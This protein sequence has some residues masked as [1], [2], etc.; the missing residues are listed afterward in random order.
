MCAM[1]STLS[2]TAFQESAV[3]ALQS[4]MQDHGSCLDMD[5]CSL[6]TSQDTS[7][8]AGPDGLVRIV[9]ASSC[10]PLCDIEILIS[11][12]PESAWAS[13]VHRPALC[14]D[15]AFWRTVDKNAEIISAIESFA[16]SWLVGD[17]RLRIVHDGKRVLFSRIW[18]TKNNACWRGLTLSVGWLW[19][20]T[21][22]CRSPCSEP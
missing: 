5:R 15:E 3:R 17:W 6:S 12:S 21:V 1:S 22:E 20:R 9:L 4:V 11:A 16:V 14:V 10:E 7:V 18:H 2:H 8:T 19:S 13:L